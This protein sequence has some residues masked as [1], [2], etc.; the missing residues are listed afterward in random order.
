MNP[1]IKKLITLQKL[2]IELRH[3]REETD[4]L[5]RRVAAAAARSA[6][7]QAQQLRLEEWI[8]KEDR[9]RR[10]L[11]SDVRSQRDRITRQ[12]RQ[13]DVVTNAAQA[14]ALE[15][16]IAF[17]EAEI[18]RIE[19]LEL[20]S[21]ERSETFDADLVRARE[22]NAAA[23]AALEGE[24]LRS[25]DTLAQHTARLAELDAARR[26]LRPHVTAS[27]LSSYDRIAKSRGT[28]LAEG[29]DGGCAG[30]RMKVRPQMWN[31]LRDRSDEDRIFTCE[32]CGRILYWDPAR[33]AP[34]R[35]A[36]TKPADREE[37]IAARIVRSL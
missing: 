7:L 9:Q 19:D 37:S 33:D 5:P 22:A 2:D 24:R 20:E 6:D 31:E 30:C 32:S 36:E 13:M 12:R 15:H 16:E 27:V 18:R 14:A 3:L 8:A 26:E 17:A 25:A 29:I 1:D 10:S 4:A 23:E 28:A 11:E 21:M 34:Q 35:S